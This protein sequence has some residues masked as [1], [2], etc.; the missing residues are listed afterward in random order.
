MIVITEVGIGLKKDHFQEI[1]LVTE[2]GVQ[3][4]VD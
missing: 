1:I 4:I 3:A 2:L